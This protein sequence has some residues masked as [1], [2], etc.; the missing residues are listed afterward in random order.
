M[1][2]FSKE[3]SKLRM[4]ILTKGKEQNH[5]WYSPINQNGR[6]NEAIINSMLRRLQ[7]QPFFKNVNCVQVYQERTLIAEYKHR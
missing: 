7:G 5:T 3:K 1:P 2:V 6:N 4:V